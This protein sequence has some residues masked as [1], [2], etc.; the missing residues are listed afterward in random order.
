[1]MLTVPAMWVTS[2]WLLLYV[3][4]SQST[5]FF[6]VWLTLFF[7]YII[8][9]SFLVLFVLMVFVLFDKKMFLAL[10]W[11]KCCYKE[12]NN[13]QSMQFLDQPLINE[14]RRYNE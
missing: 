14:T 11:H 13:R 9:A 4:H 6:G 5:L 3:I 12:P 8:D 1:M 10:P 7:P 2:A